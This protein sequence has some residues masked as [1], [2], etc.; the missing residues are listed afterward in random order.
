MTDKEIQSANQRS[1]EEVMGWTLVHPTGGVYVDS[2]GACRGWWSPM[3]R[4]PDAI[5]LLDRWLAECK[6][7]CRRYTVCGSTPTGGGFWHKV[8]LHKYFDSAGI[9]ESELLP[10]AI[11][12]AVI[13]AVDGNECV[14]DE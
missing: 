9:G 1:A 11:T 5:E 8:F 6:P 2:G 7:E 10:E 4:I 13:Q 3:T 12:L 14:R